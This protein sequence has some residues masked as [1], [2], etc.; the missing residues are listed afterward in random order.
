MGLFLLIG[1]I[2]APQLAN[3]RG[4]LAVR[5]A[6]Q[7]LKELI[8]QLPTLSLQNQ[9]VLTLR[10]TFDSIVVTTREPHPMRLREVRLNDKI[11][12]LIHNPDKAVVA[13]PSVVVSPVR[14]SIINKLYSCTLVVSLRGRVRESCGRRP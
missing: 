10:R 14:I 4:I 5:V 2:S 3:T 6:T 13:Y 12:V 1:A 8:S 11:S 9:A 7:N